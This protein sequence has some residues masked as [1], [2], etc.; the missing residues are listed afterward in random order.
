MAQNEARSVLITGANGFAGTAIARHLLAQGWRVRGSVR[1]GDATLPP[2]VEKTVTGP[3]DGMTDWS[4]ALNGIDGIVHCAARVHVLQEREADPLTAF[5]RAN[6]EATR[7]LA[8]QALAH[9]VRHF[10]FLSS[11]GAAKAESDPAGANAYQR[12]KLEAEAALRGVVAGAGMILVMLRPPLIYGPAAPGNFAR[13]ARMIAAGRPLPL[14][15]LTNRRS[16]IFVG[17]LA[18]AV[19]AALACGASPA[20]P[21]SLSDGEDLSTA[22]LAAR[23][24]RAC[25]RPARLLPCPAG[26]L[27]LGA[28]LLGQGAAAEAMTGSLTVD[29]GAIGRE[30]GWTPAFS[31]DEGLDL[32]FRG[33]TP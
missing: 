16:Q 12:S 5:R 9:S 6:V 2:G 4:G 31:V 32:T 17:N 11:I 27:R 26:L 8:Q 29:N 14:A 19:A 13:L 10:V 18:G 22:E 24:G 15:S 33:A 25:G 23:I 28:R 20:G 21:L 7:R 1:R 30:L 3:I